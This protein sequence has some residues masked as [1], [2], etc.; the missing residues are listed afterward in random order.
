MPRFVHIDI[1]SD[2]PEREAAF[3]RE[4]FGWQVTK[5]DGPVPYWLLNP[6]P[7]RT[8]AV[9]AGIAKRDQAWQTTNPTI[10]VPSADAFTAKIEKA[11]GTIVVPRTTIPAVGI[12]VTFRDPG[13]NIFSILEPVARE[14][15]TA[16]APDETGSAMASVP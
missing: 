6:D 2:D 5:L 7:H 15:P 3:F 13:G 4:V 8:G 9:G 11:G 12:L 14:A 1:A 10:D 16:V